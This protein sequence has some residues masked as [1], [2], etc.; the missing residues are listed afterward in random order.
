M[1]VLVSPAMGYQVNCGGSGPFTATQITSVFGEARPS[2]TKDA[3]GNTITYVGV[4]NRFHKGVDIVN[5][6]N[7]PD[8][9]GNPVWPIETGKVVACLNV[10]TLE[11][12]IRVQGQHI[13]DYIHI[14]AVSA[15]ICDDTDGSVLQSIVYTTTTIGTIIP[16][17]VNGRSSHLHLDQLEYIGGIPYDINP[18]T[19][20]L[21]FTDN[22]RVEF[23]TETLG[24]TS[25]LSPVI[26]VP[27]GQEGAINNTTGLAGLKTFPQQNDG[28]FLIPPQ[29]IDIL[30]NLR[31]GDSRKGVYSVGAFIMPQNDPTNFIYDAPGNMYFDELPDLSP[32]LGV[33]TVYLWRY[34]DSDAYFATNQFA[35]G[36]AR[37]QNDPDMTNSSLYPAGSYFAC[38]AAS[39][40]I[41]TTGAADI[42][43]SC[44]PFILDR[45]PTMTMKDFN[46]TDYL[47]LNPG[48]WDRY[49]MDFSLSAPDFLASFNVYNDASQSQNIFSQS[50]SAGASIASDVFVGVPS[51]TE[52]L[53]NIPDGIAHL[54]ILTDQLG[55]ETT[56][57]FSYDATPPQVTILNVQT[58]P[59]LGPV[60][61]WFVPSACPSNVTCIQGVTSECP[62][63]TVTG[64]ASDNLSGLAMVYAPQYGTTENFPS[65]GSPPQGPLSTSFNLNFN[66]PPPPPV[67]NPPPCVSDVSQDIVANDAAGN[68]TL[69]DVFAIQSYSCNPNNSSECDTI[70]S[71][72]IPHPV[73]QPLPAGGQV[74]SSL[75]AGQESVE[76]DIT[77][78]SAPGYIGIA[79]LPIQ[80]EIL[81]PGY[82]LVN[83]N[84]GWDIVANANYTG[85]VYVNIQYSAADLGITP[86]QEPYLR[87]LHFPTS[88]GYMKEARIG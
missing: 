75:V 42:N 76:V 72:S 84:T 79:Q 1:A 70:T 16:L 18:E 31:Y 6:C 71:I 54:A 67:P 24:N 62:T 66:F 59:P 83:H 12:G 61:P 49:V 5:S 45:G 23:S 11:E 73:M 25:I 55:E 47:P 43:A 52:S 56:G 46:Q 85:P 20:G 19:N 21:E 80:P 28:A 77:N 41:D 14:D 36:Q 34:A 10:G 69:S 8:G 50:F 86:A 40:L 22:E 63:F 82:T 3:N 32:T 88:E 37:D 38:A 26:P 74:F 57:Y 4:P 17:G 78:V 53:S 33:P 29:T 60:P 51:S 39:G 48:V 58:N 87:L 64:S 81:P 27:S 2:T 30:A 15:G 13:F 68:G 44:S 65:S 35:N 9:V 7:A